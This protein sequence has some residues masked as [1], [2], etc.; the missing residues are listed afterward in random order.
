MKLDINVSK[1]ITVNTGNY[2]S[3][4]PSV[5]IT[6]KDI[7]VQNIKDTYKKISNLVSNLLYEETIDMCDNSNTIQEVGIDHFI[8]SYEHLKNDIKNENENII[9]ELMKVN[10]GMFTAADMEKLIKSNE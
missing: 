7:D 5:S 3:I 2:S 9:N 8:E 4:K 6:A 1:T 10:S